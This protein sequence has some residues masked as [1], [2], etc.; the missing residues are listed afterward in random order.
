MITNETGEKREREKIK[1]PYCETNYSTL[2]GLL[3]HILEAK[4]KTME[5]NKPWNEVWRD[6]KEKNEL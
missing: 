2:G 6:I 4:C 3:T 1:C 5:I